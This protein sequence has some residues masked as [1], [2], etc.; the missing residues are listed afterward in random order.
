MLMPGQDQ[1]CRGDG[2]WDSAGNVIRTNTSIKNRR[3]YL[4]WGC[5]TKT[6]PWIKASHHGCWGWAR[7]RCSSG[8]DPPPLHAC[9]GQFPAGDRPRTWCLQSRGHHPVE[10]TATGVKVKRMG[11][12]PEG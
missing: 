5:P 10:G 9:L 11:N 2:S 12:G 7:P 1:P 8:G 4:P 6:G 3:E